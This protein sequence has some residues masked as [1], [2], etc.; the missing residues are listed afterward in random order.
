MNDL[1]ASTLKILLYHN[2]EIVTS[3]NPNSIHYSIKPIT[4]TDYPNSAES[5]PN[6]RADIF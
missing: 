3:L 1:E 6:L 5:N 2:V 4:K